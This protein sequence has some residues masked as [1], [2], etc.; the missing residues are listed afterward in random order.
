LKNGVFWDVTPCDS[1]KNR[2][3]E[4]LSASIIRVTRATRRNITEDAILQLRSILYPV[5]IAYAFVLQKLVHCRRK[6]GSQNNRF[7]GM[8]EF[9][10]TTIVL[11]FLVLSLA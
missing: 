1:C 6:I 5:V 7:I 11:D 9:S 4:K 2:V 10:L 8:L 3:S